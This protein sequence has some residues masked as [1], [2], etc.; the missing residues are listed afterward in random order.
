MEDA[1]T[2]NQVRGSLLPGTASGTASVVQ[3]TA[4]MMPTMALL[5]SHNPSFNLPA[6]RA[7]SPG[8]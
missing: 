2:P 8:S 4:S 7:V 1:Y 6:I 5:P 3:P